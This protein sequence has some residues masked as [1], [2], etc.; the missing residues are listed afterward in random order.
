MQ[1]KMRIL[2]ALTGVAGAVAA[3][4]PDLTPQ[5]WRTESS[6][7]RDPQS[8]DHSGLGASGCVKQASRPD[9]GQGPVETRRGR[10]AVRR[11]RVLGAHAA[12]CRARSP[13]QRERRTAGRS[14]HS[15]L[16]VRGAKAASCLIS[17]L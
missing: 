11:L 15:G 17:G 8:E 1:I 4:D 5:A 3:S 14:R 6:R 7:A 13:H 2:A 12:R 10:M 16:P 9:R